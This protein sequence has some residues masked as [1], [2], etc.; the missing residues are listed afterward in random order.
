MVNVSITLFLVL[1]YFSLMSIQNC[2]FANFS[3]KETLRCICVFDHFWLA[4]FLFRRLQT[5]FKISSRVKWRKEQKVCDI[6]KLFWMHN[7]YSGFEWS[8]ISKECSS[9]RNKSIINTL[10]LVMRCVCYTIYKRQASC[11]LWDANVRVISRRITITQRILTC[12]HFR[13]LRSCWG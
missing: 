9:Y 3:K 8:E 1:H 6:L 7:F 5:T 10:V 13:C 4:R 11:S 2:Q 12:V